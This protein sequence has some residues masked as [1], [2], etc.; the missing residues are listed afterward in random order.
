MGREVGAGR[1]DELEEASSRSNS[2]D[3]DQ[4]IDRAGFQMQGEDSFS[5]RVALHN[6]GTGAVDGTD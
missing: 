3:R 5:S 2:G 6:Q 4:W 1:A